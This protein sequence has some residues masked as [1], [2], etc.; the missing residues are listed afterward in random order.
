MMT[1]KEYFHLC[2]D[3][4]LTPDFIISR[5]DYVAAMNIVAL[6]AANTGAVVVAFTLE[7]THLHL[8]LY[9]TRDE[10]VNFKKM[11]EATYC[12]YAARSRSNNGPFRLTVELYSTGNDEDYI[13]NIAAYTVIQPTKDGKGIMPFDYTWGSGSL[14]FRSEN[15]IPVWLCNET[16]RVSLPIRFGSITLDQKRETIHSRTASIPDNWLI[17]EGLV[18]PSNYVDVKRFEAIFRTHN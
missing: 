5:K 16:G 10:C 9:G 7:D 11:F 14:Y 1:G 6:C 17:C 2:S 4:N 12:R 8:F 3:G 13:R 18:L 15:I